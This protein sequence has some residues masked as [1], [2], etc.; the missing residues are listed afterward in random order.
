M[1]C[2]RL[3]GASVIS[4][5]LVCGGTLVAGAA[6]VAKPADGFPKRTISIIVPFGA[7]GGSDQVA[8]AWG[9]AM[10]NV[11]GVGYQVE[12][13]PG[14]GGLAAIPDFMSRPAD[15]YTILEQTDGLMTSEAANQIEQ[16]LNKDIVPLCITQSTFSQIYI[17]PDEDRYT[18]WKSFVDYAK[19]NAG[20]VKMANIQR[21]GSMER[22]QMN[23]LE[24]AAGF[25]VNQISFDKPTE[26]YASLIGEHVD[27]LFEQPGD[28]RRFL[29]AGQMKPILT[30]LNERPE[31]FAEVPSLND[32]G[33][34]DVP[35]LQR[36]RLF[37]VQG[38]VPAERREYLS[39][40]CE[41][42]FNS[43]EYQA[44]NEKKY[45][46]LARSYYNAD[47]AKKLIEDTIGTYIKFYKKM[48]L[49][50]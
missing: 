28:V 41:V 38:E 30:V 16:K 45:M 17:R 46:H 27:V 21:E 6:E 31:L 10:K 3:I 23:A 42:A 22:V 32:V 24:E 2:R 8:R 34:A 1:N 9:A 7:G 20:K 48:G 18:D 50:K 19:A 49:V 35:I 15:G 33:L 26:R 4:V 36:I 14:G 5:V 43:D 39:K 29:E 44:F 40:A 37:W 13:K 25:K 11:T 47:D 12:N